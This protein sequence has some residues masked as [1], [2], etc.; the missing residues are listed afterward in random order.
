MIYKKNNLSKLALFIFLLAVLITN[1]INTKWL[2]Q[3]YESVL[4][5]DAL[6][7]YLYLPSTF[8]YNDLKD[9]AFADE[10]MKTYNFSSYFYQAQKAP[11]GNFVMSYTMGVSILLLPF[12][13]LGHLLAYLFNFPTD[14]FSTPY[15]FSVYMGGVCYAFLGLY[16]LRKVL[17]D[18]FS[19]KVT[20]IVLLIVAL[21]TNFFHYAVYEVGMAHVYLFALYAILIYCTHKWHK[22]QNWKYLVGVGISL[23]IAILIRPSEI[24]AAFIP[25]LWNVYSPDSFKQKLQ[26]V[27]ENRVQVAALILICFLVGL[28]Q[29]LYWKWTSGQFLYYTYHGMGFSFLSPHI[30]KGLISIKKGWLVYTPVMILSIIGFIPLFKKY[31]KIAVALLV[32]FVL[33]VYFIFSW[34]VWWYAGSFGSRPMVQSYSVLLFPI[35]ALM[36]YIINAKGIFLKGLTILFIVGC[37]VLNLFQNWQYNQHYFSTEGMLPYTYKLIFGKVNVN[38]ELVRSYENANEFDGHE[39][40]ASKPLYH[41]NFEVEQENIKRDSSI[42]FESQ[43]SAVISPESPFLEVIN[44]EPNTLEKTSPIGLKVT[45]QGYFPDWEWIYDKFSRLVISYEKNNQSFSEKAIRINNLAGE[46]AINNSN[47]YF[48]SPKIWNTVEIR[49]EL[50]MDELKKADKLKIFFWNPGTTPFYFDNLKVEV[51]QLKD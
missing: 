45:F 49:T 41:N 11:N 6:G 31:R 1:T 14:G 18:F 7:Y 16:L 38:R 4:S 29:F 44:T 42:A 35:A 2:D 47:D 15:I 51:V 20:A 12:F 34:D 50:D 9:M 13:F 36:S 40:A 3:G 23:G 25:L 46:E 19:D 26:L 37:G 48:G 39:I 32:F 10:M 30:I 21:A 28:P 24:V 43:Y 27:Q 17:L 22:A 8:I 33:N 5:W